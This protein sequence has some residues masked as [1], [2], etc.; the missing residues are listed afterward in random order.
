LATTGH[1]NNL[2][3]SGNETVPIDAFRTGDFSSVAATDPIYDPATGNPDGTGR[4]QIQCN[5]VLNVICP[6]RLSQAAK[7]LLALLPQ[8]NAP[9]FSSNYQISRPRHFDQ[10]QFD[11]RGDYFVT[12]KTVV[13]GKFSYFKANFNTPTAYGVGRRRRTA[14][15]P[16]VANA[17]LGRSRQE[18]DGRL[19][20]YLFSIPADRRPFRFFAAHYFGVAAGL[21]HQRSDGPGIPNVNL[22]TVYTSGLPQINVSDPLTSFNMGDFGLPSLSVRQTSSSTTTGPRPWATHAFKWGGDIGKFF[23]IRTGRQRPRNLHG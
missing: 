12:S 6:N 5:G 8:P 1:A 22:G 23:G 21:Q 15:S 14:R 19:S 10:D 11:T 13:F 3:A 4:T 7:N 17:A 20:A 2:F 9:G 16:G 18:L